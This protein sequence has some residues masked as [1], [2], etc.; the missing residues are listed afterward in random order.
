MKRKTALTW[1]ISFV[2][3]VSLVAGMQVV[4]VAKA[5]PFPTSPVISIES[6]TNKTY[7]A[8]SLLLNVTLVTQWDG[9]YFTSENRIVNYCVDGKESVQITQTEYRFDAEKQASIFSG[10]AALADLAE[11]T[12]NLRVNAEYHYDNGKQVFASNSN[13]N[14]TID[15]VQVGYGQFDGLPY[16]PPIVTVLSPSPNGTYNMPDVP[17][18]VT[19]QINGFVYHNIETI[20]WLNYSLD[21]QTATPMTLIVPSDLYQGYKVYGNGLLTGLS[22]GNHNITI[23]GE[24][25]IGGLSGNFNATVSFTVDA[26][27]IE[28][29]PSVPEFPSFM[30]FSLLMGTIILTAILYKGKQSKSKQR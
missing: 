7:T 4:E 9:L 17:L 2:L 16:E 3:L 13:V 5:N 11:G 15:L 8:N 29:S 27:T 26:S 14:F 12:H 24:T 19:V 22:D 20:K 6:P 18:N 21:G 1:I 23:N 28:P 30:V 25:A 10:S